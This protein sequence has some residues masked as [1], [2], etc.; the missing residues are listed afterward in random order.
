LEAPLWKERLRQV[1]EV[2]GQDKATEGQDQQKVQ[3]LEK[4]PI[5]S[6]HQANHEQGTLRQKGFHEMGE[7]HEEKS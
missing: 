7:M 3:G 5:Q 4:A 1:Q 6:L 2:P